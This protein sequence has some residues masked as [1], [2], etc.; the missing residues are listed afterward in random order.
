MQWMAV[1][2]T[3]VHTGDWYIDARMVQLQCRYVDI[4]SASGRATV[5]DKKWPVDPKTDQILLILRPLS[6][7]DCGQLVQVSLPNDRPMYSH[8][9]AHRGMSNSG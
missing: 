7:D 6:A 3:G 8:T 4:S 9:W 2:I 5:E 1:S